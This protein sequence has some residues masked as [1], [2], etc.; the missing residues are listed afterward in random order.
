MSAD[1]GLEDILPLAPLQEGLLFHADLSDTGGNPGATDGLDVY[2]MRLVFRLD[3]DLDSTALRRA[4]DTVLDRHPHLRAAFLQEGLDR[5]VQ[6]IPRTAEVPW[7]EV[8]LRD[9][10]PV[11]QRAEEQRILDEERAHRFDLTRPP[12]LRLTLLRH[13]D[14]DH[15]LILTAHHI[16]LD[17]WSV[18]L[19]GKELFSAYAQ[20]TKVPAAPALPTVRPY[21]DFLA[22]LA[23]QDRPAAESAWR[24]V[25]APLSAPTL[26]APA[27]AGGAPAVPEQ[28]VQLDLRLSAPAGEGLAAFAAARQVTMATV[29]QTAW[30]V[31]LARLTGRADV[32]FGTTVSGRPA[33]L[34]GAESMIGLF[35]NTLPVAV[36]APPRALLADIA[37]TLQAGRTKL[38]D[39]EHLGLPRIQQLAGLGE[40]FDTLL[41]VENFGVDRQGLADA[42]AA[43]GLTVRSVRG[44]DATHYPVTVVV[45]PGPET[46]IA[47]RYRPDLLTAER[48]R[49][50]GT[51][52]V[53][54]LEA[55][56]ADPTAPAGRVEL[57]TAQDRR[58]VLEDGETL[59]PESEAPTGSIPDR[60]A[61]AVA[62]DPDAIAVTDGDRAFSY[63]ELDALSDRVAR[64]LAARGAGP[65]TFVALSLEPSAE[66]IGAILGVLKTGAAY[67]PLPADAPADRI[68][69]QLV[70]ARPVVGLAVSPAHRDG[71]PATD[72]S[73]DR[74]GAGWLTLDDIPAAA[75]GGTRYTGPDI[76][77]HAAAYVIHTSGSTGRPKGVIVE[78]H[79]VLRLLDATDDECG[80]GADDVWTLFH[81]YAFDFSVWEIFGALLYGGRLVVVP[82]TTTRAPEEFAALLRRERV[83]V[84]NQTPS[85]FHQLAD[86][87]LGEDSADGAELPLRTVVFGGE[88]LDPARLTD[89]FERYGD[90]GP[91]LVNMYGITETTVHVTHRVLEADEPLGPEA[92]LS[93]VGRPLDDLSVR[94][95]DSALHPV[96]P[97]ATGELYVAGPG[98]ARGY[99]GRHALTATRFVADPYGPPGTR[100]YRTGD[101]A[102]WTADGELDYLG[103]ADEQVQIRGFRVEPGE[104]RAA[105]AALDEVADAV[106]LARPAPGGGTRLLA[107]ATPAAGPLAPDR[108]REA[109][110]EQLPDYLVPAAVIPV[111]HWPLTVNGKLDRNALPEPEEA[112]APGGRAPAT[113]QEEIIAHLFAAILEREHVGAD[114]DFFA[115]G[116][117]SLLATRLASRIRAALNVTLSVRDVFEAPTVSALARRV[118]HAGRAPE[119]LRPRPR[120]G[121]LPLSP[122]QRRLWFLQQLHGVGSD[123][124]IPFAARLTG[125]LDVPAL[126]AAVLDVMTRHES[127]RTVF[128]ATDGQPRQHIV[129]VSELPEPLTVT[130][131]TGAA[132]GLRLYVEEMA[133]TPLDVERD[134][135]LRAG[136]LRLG[137][138]QHV[139]VLVVHHIAA[140][141]WSARP[142][143]TDLA[144][145]Y[146]ARTGGAAPAWPPLPV[147]YA[148]FTLWQ[149]ASLGWD[150]DAPRPDGVVAAQLDHWRDALRDL[151][152]ELPL[153][154]D[155]P[156]PPVP[157]H[158]GGF[159]RFTVP[160][161]V[162]TAMRT[163]ARTEST[164][165]FMVAHA[166]LAALLA[167][168][169]SGQDIVIG[170]PVAGRHD[171]AL[172]DLVGFFVNNLVLRTD[173]SGDP[174]FRDLL[175]RVRETD[176]A[177]YAHA[178]VP[179]EHLVDALAPHR[180]LSR[181]PLFQVMLAY[182]NRQAGEIGLPGLT[183]TTVPAFG[184]S[185]KFDLTFTLAERDGAD[186][187]EGVLEYA[188]DLFE[189]A[190]AQALA[191]RLVRL[192]TEAVAAPT[193]PLH[194]LEILSPAERTALLGRPE[195]SAVPHGDATA[196]L[197][198]L[199]ATVA[200]AHPG[201]P[202][203]AGPDLA[204][205][206]RTEL[207][208]R[209]LDTAA[210]AL[211]HDL[212]AHGVRPQDRVAVML[213]RTVEAV[214]ALLA[215]AKT[216]A[217]Y[218]PVDPDYPAERI[219]HMLADAAPTLVLTA[220]GTPASDGVPRMEADGSLLAR[221]AD[222]PGLWRTQRPD[223]AAYIIYTSGSTGRPKGVAVTHTGLP[224]L[225]R[226]LSDAFGA[227][228]GDRVLQFASLSFDTSVWE[229]VMALFS[230]A[231]LEIVPADRRLGEPLAAFLAEH[232]VTHLTVPP[233]VLA[234]LPE[235]AVAPGTTLIVAGEACTPAL[236]RAWA[237]RT[238]MFNSY[239]PTETTVDATLW[240]CD[241]DRLRTEDTSPVP[242]GAA[243][244]ETAALV[245]DAALR[246][247]PPG[248]PGELYVAGSGLARGYLGRPGLTA[249]R[250]VAA[251]FGPPGTR[252]YRTGDLA[253]RRA[254]G[255]L[256]YLGRADHQV[257]LR[258]FRIELGEIESALTALDGVRQA[259]AVLREDRPGHR[260]LAAYA[261]ARPG[262]DLDP[263]RLRTELART[264]PDYAV[265]ATLTLLPAL[266]LGPT[267]KVDRAALPAPVVAAADD[268]PLTGTAATLAD[269]FA[270]VLRLDGPPGGDDSFFA[271]GGDSISS[272]Q[273]VARARKSGL[274]LTARQIFE[275]PSPRALADV[276]APHTDIEAVSDSG[277]E[278]ASA[279]ALLTPLMHWLRRNPDH[280]A[281]FHQSML[282]TV[283]PTLTEDRLR[284]ALGHLLATHDLLRARVTTDHSDGRPRLTPSDAAPDPATLL[285]V[286]PVDGDDTELRRAVETHSRARAAELDPAD[287][288]LVRAVWFPRGPSRDGRLLLLI[289][290][291]A[292]DGVSWRILLPDL[293]H[294]V[295]TGTPPVRPGTSFA[296]WSGEL[297]ADSE[298]FAVERSYWHGVLA[299]RPAPLVPDDAAN[300]PHTPGELRTELAP[301]L[302]A[303]LLTATAAAFHARPDEL[304]LAALVHAVGG[305]TPVLVD[306]ESHGRHE[307]LTPGADLSRT[308]GWF[309]TQYPVR[310]DPGTAGVGQDVKRVRDRLA[311][312]PGRGTG[313]G[314]LHGQVPSGAQIAFNYLG[315]FAADTPDGHWV[316]APESD[317]VHPGPQPVLL[318]GH[319]LDLNASTLD[320]PE[321]PVLTVRW[322]YATDVIG[323]ERI[324]ALADRFTAALTELVRRREEPGF[325]GHS[326]GDFPVALDQHEITELE[327]ASPALDGVLPLTPL[328]HGLA[329]HALTV[330]SGA[331]PYVVQLELEIGGPLD[332]GRLR[333]AA[334]TVV[335]RHA[336]L[337]AGFRRL[338]TGRLVQY[339]TA[340]AAP[341]WTEHD[342]RAHPDVP[343]T[344]ALSVLVTEDRV[345][346]FAP[347]RPPLLRFTLIRTADDRW[348]LLFTSHHLLLDGW[349]AP[350][351]LTDLFDAYAGRSPVR[352]RPFADYARWLADRD[353]PA[354]EA[355]WRTALEGVTEPT[356]TA[357]ADTPSAALVPEE[358]ATA[359]D[360]ALTA[361]LQD[362]ARAAG[363][364][365]N[366]V[367]QTGWGLVLSRLTGRD[368]VVFGSAVS[369]RPA[370]LDGVEGML[371]LFVNTLPTRVRTAPSRTLAE[372]VADLHAR[373][374]A[375]LDHQ[376]LGLADIQQLVGLPALL[377]TMTVF[378]NYPFDDEALSGSEQAAGL[379]V[380]GIGGRDATHYPLTLAI[381]LQ[382]GRLRLVLKHRPDLYDTRAAHTVLDRLTR[383]LDHLAHRPDLPA[384][385]VDLAPEASA[386]LSGRPGIT[387]ALGCAGTVAAVAADT[388]DAI[389]VRPLEDGQQPVTYAELVVRAARFAQ[390]LR[391]TGAGPE[392]VVAL[393]LP[394]SVDLVVAELAVAW[395]GAA[396]LPLHPDW[397]AERI[398]TV[399]GTAGAVALICRPGTDTAAYGPVAVLHPDGDR[400]PSDG[401]PGTLPAA[402]APHR[403]SY[404]MYTSGST[405]EPKGV[406]VPESAVLALAS[407]SRFAGDAQRRVLVHS[408][409]S[410]DAATHEI[411]GTLL[412]GGE[413]VLA[414]DTPLDPARWREL[415]T[416]AGP[417]GGVD[418]AWFT[419]G[420]FALIAQDAPETFTALREVWTG[421]D[422]V[423][424][425]AVAAARAAAPHLRVVNGYGPTETTTFATSHDLGPEASD[426]GPLPIGRPLDGMTLRVL[427]T[428]LR[429]VLPGVPGELYIGGAGLA[430][431][432]HG[433]PGRTAERFVADPQG[434]PGERLYRTGDL[435][436]IRPDGAL[437]FLGRT[438][439]Q[440]KL[441]GHRVEPGESEAALLAEPGVARAAV[442]LRTDLPGGP[443]L[444]G[445]AVP[446]PGTTLDTEALRRRLAA[447][448]PDYQVPAH[449][450]AL[451][452]LPLTENGKVDRAALP[453]PDAVAPADPGPRMPSDQRTELLC[454]VFADTLG[455]PAFGPHEDFFE[456]GGHSLSAM[457]LVGRARTF[458][459]ADLSVG[460]LFTA[461]TPAATA[462]LL[463]AARTPTR[464]SADVVDR[465]RPAEPP[466]SAAQQ[467]LWF[468]HRLEEESGAA[469]N[470]PIALRLTGTLDEQ[471]L[472]RALADLS[473]R[474][475]VLRT[476]FPEREGRAVQHIL[477]PGDAP[478]PLT[479][480]TTAPDALDAALAEAASLP[481]ALE[482]ETPLRAGLFRVAAED[483]TRDVL[484]L[485]LHHI[486]GDEWSVRP[487][488]DDL[489]TALAAR[490]D[491]RSPEW[492]P[493]PLQ[494]AD[495][496]LRQQDLLG[497]E[498]DEDSEISRQVR[499]WKDQLA[500]LAPE[501]PLPLDRP[502]RP[503]TGHEGGIVEFG[504]SKEVTAGLRR[505]AS[506]TGATPFMVAHAALTVLLHRIGGTDDVPVGTL[507]AG[508]DDASVHDLVGFFVNTLV[509][510]T[511][512]GG[513]PTPAQLVARARAAT[514]DALDHADVP[515]ERLVDL[516][517]VERSL[518]RHPLFQV[519]L[520]YQTRTAEGPDLGGLS[521]EPVAVHTRTAKFDLTFTLVQEPGADGTL[522]G[523]ITY[524][525]GLFDAATV[526]R[527]ANWY[528]RILA[529]F[530]A[531]PD[532]PVGGCRLLTE[533][534]HHQ[535]LTTWNRAEEPV[536]PV[537]LARE[538]AERAALVPDAQ[539]V[540][541]GERAIPYGQ[542]LADAQSLAALLRERGVRHGESVA[543]LL[544]RSAE[545]VTAA[546]AVLQAGGAYLP[547]DPD[548]PAV[549]LSA[550][551]DENPPAVLVTDRARRGLLPDGFDRPVLLLD[552]P[553]PA[554][555]AGYAPA[556]P[557]PAQPA[558]ILHT[559][560]STGR[561]KAV[562]VPHRAIANRL[563]WTQRRFPLGPGDRMLAKAT[564]GF[565]VSVWELTGPLLAGATVVLAGPDAHR[566]P[567]QLV[568]L[569]SE[570]D[571]HAVHFVPSMLALFA[572]EPEA[573]RCTSLRWIF[574]GGEALTDTLVRRC[575]E[576]FTAPV[577]NQYG[578]TEAAVDVT[579]RT[580]LPGEQSLVPLGAPGAGSRAYVLDAALRP[581]PPGVSGE[582][583]LGGAQLA[584]GYL[585]R[586]AQT[587]ERFVADPFGSPGERLYR[588]GDLARWNVRG[589]MEY[590]RRADDQVKLRGVR[591]EPEEVRTAL[592][593]HPDV[594]D[595]L[596]LVRD[597]LPG[598]ARL[599]GYVTPED[600]STS[601]APDGLIAHCAGLLPGALVPSDVV[602][603]DRFPLTV[604]GKVDRAAL[605]APAVAG[606]AGDGELPEDAT[607]QVLAELIADL[608]KLPAVGRH[609]SFFGLGGDSITSIVLV[610]AARR[611][612]LVISPRDVFEQRTVS[613]LARVARREE[614]AA[615]VHDPGAGAV[616]L[617]PVMHA[618]RRR[619]GDHRGYHQS[620]L[621]TTPPGLTAER[622]RRALGRLIAHHPVLAARLDDAW[623]LHVP[624]GPALDDDTLS[625]V[626]AGASLT[627]AIAS[628]SRTAVGELDP[629]TGRMLRAVLL[630]REG[631][632][633]GRL[634]LVA[635]HLVVDAVSWRILLPDLAQLCAEPDAPL[636]PVETSFRSWSRALTGNATDRR[637]ELPYWS[638][639]LG[640]PG[641]APYGREP[642]PAIDTPDTVHRL[643]TTVSADLAEPALN[644][645]T[646]AFHCTEQDVLLAA[647]VLAHSRWRSESSTLVLL[648]GHG[649][650]GVLPEVAAPARTVGWF[651]SQYPFRARLTEAGADTTIADPNTAGRLLKQIKEQL[652]AV[653]DHGIGYG[654]L[655]HLDTASEAVLAARPEP[656]TGFNYLGRYDV[657]E[658]DAAAPEPWTPSPE[659]AAVW[660]PAPALGVHTAVDLDITALRRPSGTELSVSWHHAARLVSDEEIAVLDR[661]WRT[662]LETLVA[663][664]RTQAA[665]HTPSDLGL[666]SLSQDEIDEFE[667][668]W[669][670]T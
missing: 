228:P 237:P 590:L 596:V 669:R 613:A 459:D 14:Q 168:T 382:G 650:D 17:G 494:Y 186:G 426:G 355:A 656:R 109:L 348:R 174:S 662:A 69:V 510:R 637:S 200:A 255:E 322:T 501:L 586:T 524:R 407:D 514:L 442:T 266:P 22:W 391:E 241:P 286:V 560:G 15:T 270:D 329:Y 178:D 145:A 177:A 332:P 597:D 338:T 149:R 112:A 319:V 215:V 387:A 451:D 159:A 439:D 150:D 406:A 155:R 629:H 569:I 128:P 619:G 512:V 62:L 26:L 553:R 499:Y 383:A 340:D 182:E 136:L 580:A 643:I 325:A 404:V 219:A 6:V 367:V 464:S 144:T 310:L 548:H 226:T 518:E 31:A 413:L 95:L 320:G 247:V 257:K 276:V 40:L 529:A 50:L 45:H 609:D 250:F 441:R 44:E 418:S 649:R 571:V 172:D 218:L 173:L 115:L 96:A 323:P 102:R 359:L 274:A 346:P 533:T 238:R 347:D 77:P 433:H 7:R 485:V 549:R 126:R 607:E 371:G 399:L 341:E 167:R 160:P 78:H 232:R 244:A 592:L 661:W 313:Y 272:I 110:R 194:R 513:D 118:H 88:A 301:D 327:A 638:Q 81:S 539:A 414:P 462:A 380:R 39:H 446:A 90:D 460:D 35:I 447:R 468:L 558:Y 519:M 8:D 584:L 234:A 594:R 393:L 133:R 73:T 546:H 502:R 632:E 140:D 525:T 19:L 267:G 354:A 153:P 119:P 249:T 82:R 123:Y 389:A 422:V 476:V 318:D 13:G 563:A 47:L 11:R 377:D 229:I 378:E 205:G 417:G 258:G 137:P 18:P 617:T 636:P 450:V 593:G 253:R 351:L 373:Q 410:F 309:T 264:L 642:D 576:V 213:P 285:T 411:W 556:E 350:L 536:Q 156:R 405:G 526:R 506:R 207:D 43:G 89:W 484:L 458:L 624:E 530:A 175:H 631:G 71:L 143:L 435:V 331:D 67:L 461:R 570:H 240:R 388:P 64:L 648:E 381:T 271:L 94:L 457:S 245:L 575:A 254:D 180:S 610:S 579:A 290:H 53:R 63:R 653:P 490:T 545:L 532:R 72:G 511:D 296:H 605:P 21:R 423:S 282:V 430:R 467:R 655:R 500:G 375:L 108:L 147:Q 542:L 130:E 543:V 210:N 152:A 507:V 58:R 181:H 509:L 425:G 358:T 131:A 339:T 665:G 482:R 566:D 481:F 148:D 48:A 438:D 307:E 368:D 477:A 116:G 132:D 528:E 408:P 4:A 336:N 93:P 403:L 261:V 209:Q 239:G 635:H 616:P 183:T 589:E 574:S 196:T 99:L 505:L 452:A 487:L 117:H 603:L 262:A 552:D 334:G 620:L 531:H 611:R 135:P 363:T 598:A 211:A 370:E 491:G 400:T 85:A 231:A 324:R 520:N 434:A 292:V 357:P 287:G 36:H 401:H 74:P 614:A 104:A 496:T 504:L 107:Y 55:L 236:V 538:F 41:V 66:Q 216:G 412:R 154:T 472:E 604:S 122:A 431:G 630:Q 57:L 415:L 449:L 111:D 402:P 248:T 374:V 195:D 125:P 448:L 606:P 12:L 573:A 498:S 297:Y 302:T 129:D 639:V 202:A 612:G 141:Q 192:L 534:E 259:A 416:G 206:D 165:L 252:M 555:P 2:T 466:L 263:D 9:A 235:D 3:G 395:T 365:L 658:T 279:P 578:P 344:D 335:D 440:V 158:R 342:L 312:V 311:A 527:I 557:H 551:L 151:P 114:D 5:P 284:T 203:L 87:L 20:H 663:A 293:A 444:V 469:Y 280:W 34:D 646:A 618:L 480:R 212:V 379:D 345:R 289:H 42:Q 275:H 54:T 567:A 454:Q 565:D 657:G 376:H 475:E 98:L 161:A 562:A 369:G 326:P 138:D 427:D 187:I 105:L 626:Q 304:L 600:P 220:P 666:L 198:G 503:G 386:T 581:V 424:P 113:P 273:L 171:T 251:P 306:L 541:D 28:P 60:F 495:H 659:S 456:R 204:T 298:R 409:H 328:Q 321:G 56:A 647:F 16:L 83:T 314:A 577:V 561:P 517:D 146:A 281:G 588:T 308:V 299:D 32:A 397:P 445:Y 303:P 537:S 164:S 470:V 162:H 493:L 362:R 587:A 221:T 568:R 622:L 1:H 305:D 652:R 76:S 471:A 623:T 473:A 572:A 38:L 260:L 68:R 429:P 70:S 559:S 294:A 353:R 595:A 615:P 660:R 300:T 268:T 103:R 189:P 364:T 184:R 453:A 142:L 163:L 654:Q 24:E 432:Y 436:R 29:H 627:D 455:L 33:D 497:D 599:V 224:A 398:R 288:V 366:T 139:V 641:P 214:V 392:T 166:A 508:R 225:A 479:V 421:G 396:Y 86:V 330:G 516:L 191:D 242:V 46:R 443:A 101:L 640:D 372:A 521:S 61:A 27:A 591:I 360:P 384:G 394:R 437:D 230:G 633:P 170:T 621:V 668:E 197:P 644:E 540:I 361:A 337:R 277:V 428:A 474:H 100:M 670:T 544:P 625:V 30:G 134:V 492:T 317:A 333:A 193:A 65:G 97:G 256:E 489:A 222:D 75:P 463:R 52:Y 535:L 201:A 349:S 208:Y 420:L 515:F 176:L 49:A 106:V 664:A 356:L 465:P 37:T 343:V 246:P 486:A 547:L 59:A 227:G 23:A 316:P 51:A 283:E 582:L 92:P 185:A 628:A 667:D 550:M 385:Q 585:G 190:T 601:P 91:E 217:V 564:P 634:L 478:V 84:L 188:E 243:V 522:N 390:R 265:P 169:G 10:E 352:R 199:F 121:T 419:A 179:F 127:L 80:F 25:L 223:A 523:G 315:R 651:T 583:Y 602:V 124:A 645:V 295:A 233:A 554:A 269:L 278:Q 608:L 483:G 488:L 79:N 120:P 157:S 291:L